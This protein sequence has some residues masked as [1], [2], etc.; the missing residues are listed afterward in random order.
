M[1]L[2]A[3]S[4]LLMQPQNLLAISVYTEFFLPTKKSWKFPFLHEQGLKAEEWGEILQKCPIA[5]V[6]D[7]V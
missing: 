1:G 5:H 2:E 4:A 6:K 3:E 7:V